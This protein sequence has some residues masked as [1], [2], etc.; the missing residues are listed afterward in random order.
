MKN[1]FCS[2][3][4]EKLDEGQN[5]CPNCKKEII[6]V[7]E[8]NTL[9]TILDIIRYIIGSILILISIGG[10]IEGSWYAIIS[11]ICGFSLFPF[12]YRN[13]LNKY[14]PNIKLIKALQVVI[15]LI[16]FV[17]FIMAIPDENNTYN[18]TSNENNYSEEKEN[19]NSTQPK[20]LTES[21]KMVLKLSTLMDSKLVIDSGDYVKGDVPAGEYAFIRFGSGQYYSEEDEAGNI[22]D[23]ENFDSFGYVKVHEAGDISTRGILVNVTAF[24]QIG[25]KSAK[26]LYEILNEKTDWNQSGIYK[27]G[28]DIEAG[29]YTL[30]SLGSGYYAILTGPVGN[31]D[32]VD[33]DNFNGKATVTIKNGQYLQLSRAKFSE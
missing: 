25:V 3:C 18:N 7:K 14:I 19:N 13:C 24:E 31:N 21:E 33:N 30:E 9:K 28:I 16:L 8:K 23:N 12:I 22:I 32:I 29:R 4:G 26:E 6:K 11:I 27:V 10:L 1:K 5:I 2:N 15:P 17:T 20:E